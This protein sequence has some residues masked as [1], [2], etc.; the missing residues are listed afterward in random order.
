VLLIC[1]FNALYYIYPVFVSQWIA[2]LCSFLCRHI[3]FIICLIEQDDVY[4]IA[5]L[6]SHHVIINLTFHVQLNVKCGTNILLWSNQCN[7]ITKFY[8]YCCKIFRPIIIFCIWFYLCKALNIFRTLS[9]IA[10]N[11]FIVSFN[12]VMFL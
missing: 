6:T 7:H 3:L 9:C 1:F 2:L 4:S 8:L 11:I 5:M 12:V 10:A